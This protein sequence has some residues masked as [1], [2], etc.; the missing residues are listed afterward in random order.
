[1]DRYLSLLLGFPQGTVDKSM[2][3]PSVSQDEPPLGKFERQ[4]TV[5]TSRILERN[6]DVLNT[7]EIATTQALDS[8][9][10]RVSRSMLANFRRPVSFHRITPGFPIY[11]LK[12]VCLGTQVYYYGLL[13]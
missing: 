2:G 3:A 11:L 12:T 10:L 7:T 6:E 4:L 9:V 8:G 1:M 5:V 13:F